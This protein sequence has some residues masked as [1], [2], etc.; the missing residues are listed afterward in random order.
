MLTNG[1]KVTERERQLTWTD[2]VNEASKPKTP[3]IAKSLPQL[4]RPIPL[5]E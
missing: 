2:S 1:R 3:Q 4:S 5:W